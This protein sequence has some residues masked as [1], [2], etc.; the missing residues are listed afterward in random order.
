MSAVAQA[1]KGADPCLAVRIG[2]VESDRVAGER[3]LRPGESVAGLRFE[4]AGGGLVVHAPRGVRGRVAQ[5]RVAGD[6]APGRTALAVGARGK[7][8]TEGG[9]VLF[10]VVLAPPEPLRR[11]DFRA[12]LIDEDDPLFL[13]LLGALTACATV[14]C[15]WVWSTPLPERSG[16]E[17]VTR[18]TD[19]LRDLPP[20]VVDLPVPEPDTSPVAPAP[21]PRP[22]PA[23]EPAAS[24]APSSRGR[25]IPFVTDGRGST[26]FEEI[27]GP[28]DP[29][30]IREQLDLVVSERSADLSGFRAA[31]PRRDERVEVRID[32]PGGASE[33]GE[34]APLAVKTPKPRVVV[35][36]DLP[37]PPPVTIREALKASQARFENCVTQGLK[38]DPTLEGRVSV[39]WRIVDGR[40][41]GVEIVDNTTGDDALGACFTRAVGQVRFP[42]G[43]S[44][45][46]AEFPWAI[47]GG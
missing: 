36:P 40:A 20:I 45:E 35:H 9:A 38:R 17:E 26:V 42:P 34:G 16:H 2:V 43:T 3:L 30:F 14:F 23:P 29:G 46:V 24:P 22:R 11:A 41:T 1:A 4:A 18:A 25:V 13:G 5:G 6:L 10:Q 39:G 21:R 31:G 19:A 32:G 15:A 44:A 33:I 12:T 27:L 47:S 8:E 37:K 28:D 7:V